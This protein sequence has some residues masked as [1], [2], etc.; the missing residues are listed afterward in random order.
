M[1]GYPFLDSDKLIEQ[2]TKQSIA[3]IFADSGEEYFRELETN[4]LRVRAFELQAGLRLFPRMFLW[5]TTQALLP[6]SVSRF[7]MNSRADARK[8]I[9]ARVQSSNPGSSRRY[10][11]SAGSFLNLTRIKCSSKAA[12]V[13]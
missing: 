6:C 13:Y 8:Y 4:V 12:Q 2:L 9:F 3:E 5:I 7:R 1:L 10:C 11:C